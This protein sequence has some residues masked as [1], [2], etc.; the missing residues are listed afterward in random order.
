MEMYET[1]LDEIL[2]QPIRTRIMTML[3]NTKE[4]DFNTIKKKLSLTDGHMSTHMKVLLCN[5]Y[6]SMEKFFENNKPKTVY[7]PTLKGEKAFKNYIAV[8]RKIIEG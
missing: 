2:H 1:Q 8:L 4:C 5:E 6:V 3:I 7:K